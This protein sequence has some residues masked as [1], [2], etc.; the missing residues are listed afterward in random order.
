[1]SPAAAPVGVFGGTFNPVH[2]GHLRSA[3]EVV[4]RLGLERLHLMP[5]ARPPHR[6]APDCSAGDRAAMVELAVRDEPRLVCD[7]REL[8]RDGPSYTVDSLAGLRAE[9]G[10]GRGLCMM[11]GVDAVAGL[12]SWHRWRELLDH[13]HLVVIARPGWQLPEAG[14]VARWLRDHRAGDR[15]ALREAPCGRV[16]VEELRQL[17]ISST[18]IREMLAAGRSARFLLP[19]PVLDYIESHHLYQHGEHAHGTT[20]QTTG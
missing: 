2:L 19:E 14:V 6:E 18:G 15:G 10:P 20:G 4:E 8:D 12:D 7:R 3:V 13:A 5:S 9:L 16:L 11:L 1:M 17:D